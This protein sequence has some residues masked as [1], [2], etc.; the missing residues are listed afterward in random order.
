MDSKLATYQDQ[1]DSDYAT[2]LQGESA[3]TPQDERAYLTYEIR[4]IE[5]ILATDDKYSL[6]TPAHWNERLTEC[7]T[8]LRRLLE[9]EQATIQGTIDLHCAGLI[10]CNTRQ[11]EIEAE[12]AGM[13][14]A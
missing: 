6:V 7:R 2:Y 1:Q 4:G 14:V 9:E 5:K 11:I 3:P 10:R 8:R 12:L 13:E